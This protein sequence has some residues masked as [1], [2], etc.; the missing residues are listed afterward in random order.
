M[1]EDVERPARGVAARKD[2]RNGG[3]EGEPGA[4]PSRLFAALLQ[5]DLGRELWIFRAV[6]DEELGPSTARL[7]ASPANAGREA[8]AKGVGNQKGRFFW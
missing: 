3:K 6:F 7:R 1:R 2:L 8:F 4:P 5:V